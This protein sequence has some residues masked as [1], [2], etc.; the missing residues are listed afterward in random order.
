[1][2]YKKLEKQN[3]ILPIVFRPHKIIEIIKTIM[4][5]VLQAGLRVIFKKQNN[6]Y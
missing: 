3:E 4:W 5:R 2:Q 1:M 6:I